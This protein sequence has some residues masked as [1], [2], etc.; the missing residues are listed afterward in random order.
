MAEWAEVRNLARGL[1]TTSFVTP[2]VEVSFDTVSAAVIYSKRE[3]SGS[4]AED[5]IEVSI[6]YAFDGGLKLNLSWA[7]MELESE[8][9]VRLAF[10]L[11][12]P[13]SSN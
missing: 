7:E 2:A 13:I 8:V 5:F 4:P 3:S 1:D 9:F 11:C 10:D 12:I 6:G